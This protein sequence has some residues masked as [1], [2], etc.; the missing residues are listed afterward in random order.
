M[1]NVSSAVEIET[2][3]GR[4][5]SIALQGV[6]D[7]QSVNVG[8]LLNCNNN[9][10]R[11]IFSEKLSKHVGFSFWRR[12]SR[13]RDQRRPGGSP[14]RAIGGWRGADQGDGAALRRSCGLAG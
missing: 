12:S 9:V 6:A 7:D 11:A 14:A 4:V 1:A 2:R 13:A 3:T 8:T 5:L 10:Q